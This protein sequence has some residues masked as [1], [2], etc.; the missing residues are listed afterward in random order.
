MRRLEGVG[1]KNQGTKF[2]SDG[3]RE[4][5]ST[6]TEGKEECDMIGVTAD[7]FVN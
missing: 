2:A 7:I 6:I 3:S 1:Y 4:M 5:L